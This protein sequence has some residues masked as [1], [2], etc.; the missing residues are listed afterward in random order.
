VDQGEVS[1]RS[2]AEILR[3]A[4]PA[5]RGTALIRLEA[6]EPRTHGDLLAVVGSDD[7]IGCNNRRQL[8]A[9]A[10]TVFELKPVFE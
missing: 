1:S 6:V 9:A 8:S 4:H 5:A 2:G 3:P 7:E 10:A